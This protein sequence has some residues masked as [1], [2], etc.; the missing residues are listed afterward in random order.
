[1]KRS[2]IISVTGIVEYL[3]MIYIMLGCNTV[4]LKSTTN[5]YIQEITVCITL[6]LFY[7]KII[8][9]SILFL[10]LKRWELFMAP[11]LVVMLALIIIS[12]PMDVFLGFSVRF[13]VFFPCC[14]L[15]FCKYREENKEYILIHK[16]SN[17]MVFLSS[18]SLFFWIF[19][20]QLNVIQPTGTLEF[21]WGIVQRCP[22]YYGLY[23]TRQNASM[24]IYSGLRNQSIFPEAPMFSLCLCIAIAAELFLPK[25]KKFCNEKCNKSHIK[26]ERWKL[27]LLISALITTITT[28]GYIVLIIMLFIK[29]ILVN[30]KKKSAQIIKCLLLAVFIV[31][32]TLAIS[33]IFAEKSGSSSW[34]IRM[35]DFR[36]GFLAWKK[37]PFFGSGYREQD[38][39][40]SF[41][42]SFRSSN[43]G[44]SNSVMQILAQGGLALFSVYAIPMIGDLFTA[45]KRGKWGETA[46]SFV[47]IVEFIFTIFS[48]TL[49]LIMIL[50]FFCSGFLIRSEGKMRIPF[51]FNPLN[52]A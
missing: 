7:L 9:G 42:S 26:K 11:Y 52:N 25:T 5:Y 33:Y 20:S 24:F 31:V 38:S 48:Y 47:I 50:A 13:L 6:L 17:I 3:L 27:F 46:F 44:F 10:S 40:Q 19:A 16:F 28:T 18:T 34:Q 23:V 21:T 2:Y 37:A 32:C 36:S 4:Y 39:I 29:Y 35:D 22:S 49:F 12:V 1:M 14:V 30:P 51:K 43:R 45:V 15:I 41:M 8:R